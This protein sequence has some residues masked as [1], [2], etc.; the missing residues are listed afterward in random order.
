MSLLEKIQTSGAIDLKGFL[1]I[2]KGLLLKDILRVH[3][4]E[5]VSFWQ[6]RITDIPEITNRIDDWCQKHWQCS[7]SNKCT[8]EISLGFGE[9]VLDNTV[10]WL[11]EKTPH[12][13]AEMVDIYLREEWEQ[14]G[15]II[16][17]WCFSERPIR[18]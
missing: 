2:K 6:S 3:S 15:Q 4:A 9:N 17:N 11:Q 16:V 7:K 8:C 14:I 12:K 13:V 5:V 18:A 1:D 10:S